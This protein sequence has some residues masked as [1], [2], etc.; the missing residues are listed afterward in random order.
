MTHWVYSVKT[1]VQDNNG[2]NLNG[3]GAERNA[4]CTIGGQDVAHTHVS[5][6]GWRQTRASIWEVQRQA[7]ALRQAGHHV[8]LCWAPGHADIKGNE[9]ADSEARTATLGTRSGTEPFSVSRS[10][11]DRHLL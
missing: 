1:I 2:P 8:E 9:A 3:L 5:S 11:L 7:L 6:V 10:M 4:N